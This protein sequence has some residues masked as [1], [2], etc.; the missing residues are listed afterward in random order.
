MS[1]SDGELASGSKDSSKTFRPK[2][3]VTY[4]TLHILDCSK[5][6]TWVAQIIG[7]AIGHQLIFNISTVLD[8]SIS[9]FDKPIKRALHQITI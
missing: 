8:I 1:L 6:Y 9:K 4:R 3:F 5:L 7:S 2:L